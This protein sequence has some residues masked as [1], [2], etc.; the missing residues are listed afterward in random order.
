MTR[1][2]LAEPI[3]GS[4]ALTPRGPTRVDPS[5]AG[6]SKANLTPQQMCEAI[7]EMEPLLTLLGYQTEP[8]RA[9]GEDPV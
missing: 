9:N 7:E 6:K 2:C 4:G 8:D 1:L 3:P 5:R